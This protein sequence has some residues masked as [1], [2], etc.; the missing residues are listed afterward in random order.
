L[1][2]RETYGFEYAG[3]EDPSRMVSTRELTEDKVLECL[4]KIL[5]GVSVIPH[6]VDE[7]TAASPPH[8][9]SVFLFKFIVFRLL[10]IVS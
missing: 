10:C 2:A 3:A 9:V 7:Y 6:R 1:K 4:W 5:K 8:A